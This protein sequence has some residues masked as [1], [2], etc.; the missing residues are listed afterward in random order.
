MSR[1]TLALIDPEALR[2][3]LDRVRT[4]APHSRVW[5]VVKADGY[6]HGAVT[7][8]RSLTGADGFAVATLGE[9]EQLRQAGFKQPILLL[10]GTVNLA[11]ARKAIELGCDTVVHQ[12]EQISQLEQCPA[13]RAEQR[14]WLKI[15]TGMHRLGVAPESVKT[16]LSRL[17]ALALR[18]PVGLMTHFASADIDDPSPTDQQL[19]LFA[20]CAPD[21][22]PACLANSA[23]VMAH[24]GSHRDWVRPGI[25][26]YGASPGFGKTGLDL[27]LVPAMTLQAPVIALR[28]IPKGDQVGYGGRW[29]ARRASRIATLAIGYGDGYPRHA[30]DGTPVWLRGCKVPLVGKVSMDMLTV[31]VTDLEGIEVGDIAELWGA[32]LSVDE[33]ARHIDTIGY[34]LLTRVSQRVERHIVSL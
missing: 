6:G 9:A 32:Q 16:Y 7:A 27:G 31:D 5:A 4:L 20:H 21:N 17:D 2:A 3:N 8:A 12:A 15:D 23:G 24:P 14:V 18:H 22:H 10:E 33:V 30:P 11:Q 25:M 26:L 19:A 29:Q 28:E 34:E 13:T 1:G